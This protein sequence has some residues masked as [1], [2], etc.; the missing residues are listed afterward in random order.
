A[1]RRTDCAGHAHPPG[2][3]RD[4]C[5]A[6]PIGIA[7]KTGRLFH[8]RIL[9]YAFGFAAL[10]TLVCDGSA[11]FYLWIENLSDFPPTSWFYQNA[12]WPFVIISLVSIPAI[13]FGMWIY[14]FA[15]DD[16]GWG[17]K[18]GWI[19]AF[20]FTG[21]IASIL[22]FVIVYRRQFSARSSMLSS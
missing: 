9:F 11:F 18:T 17:D 8:T 2:A 5:G 6:G 22:Y 14:L 13:Y 20:F 4:V 12:L 1:H 3:Q 19:I 7:R 16:S 15:C 10:W 21:P